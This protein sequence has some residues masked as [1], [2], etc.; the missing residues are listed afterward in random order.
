MKIDTNDPETN[1]D[2]VEPHPEGTNVG[3][4]I[5]GRDN[6]PRHW[7]KQVEWLRWNPRQGRTIV[8]LSAK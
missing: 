3:W 5:R 2:I 7:F 4:V 6:E 8:I 1:T